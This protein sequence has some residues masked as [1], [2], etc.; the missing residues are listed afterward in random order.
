MRHFVTDEFG[1]EWRLRRIKVL[2]RL[3][4]PKQ[5]VLLFP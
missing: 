4:N 1:N 3:R 2:P 5:F